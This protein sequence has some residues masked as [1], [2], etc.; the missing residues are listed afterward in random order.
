VGLTDRMEALGGRLTVHSPPGAGTTLQVA[1]PL[2]VPP[3]PGLLTAG[4]GP[5][6][7]TRPGH[8]VKPEHPRNR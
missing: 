7:G 3:E 4:T 8:S 5:P 6:D 2:N 1:L